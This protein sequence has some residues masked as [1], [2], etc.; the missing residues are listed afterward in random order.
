MMMAK[1]RLLLGLAALT[2]SVSAVVGCEDNPDGLYKKAPAGAGD[3]WNNGRTPA[4]FDPNAINGLSDSFNSSSRQELCSGAEKAER[5]KAMVRKPIIPPRKIAGIDL[6]GGDDWRGLDFRQAEQDLCQSK[7]RKVDDPEALG[8]AWGDSNEVEVDYSIANNSITNWQLNNGYRGTLDFKSRKHGLNENGFEDE[9]KANP[10]GEHTYSI[11]IGLQILKD[12]RPHEIDWNTECDGNSTPQSKCWQVQLTE[13][14]DGLMATFDPGL[15]STQANCVAEQKCLGAQDPSG[16]GLFGVRPLGVYF[17]VPNWRV[18]PTGSTPQYFYGF[19][20]KLMPF[21]AANLYVKLDDEG[22]FALSR[23]IGTGTAKKDC[24][25]H[26]G[27][28]YKDF[29]AN[30]V[31]VFEDKKDS[32]FFLTKLKGGMSHTKEAFNFSVEAV[33]LDFVTEVGD[34]KTVGDDWTPQNEDKAYEF[35]MDIRASGKVLNEFTPDEKAQTLAA[36]GAIYREYARRV[37]DD[38]HAKLADLYGTKDLVDFPAVISDPAKNDKGELFCERG[39]LFTPNDANGNPLLDSKGNPVQK[40]TFQPPPGCAPDLVKKGWAINDAWNTRYPENNKCVYV[41]FGIGAEQCLKDTPDEGCTGFEALITPGSHA[42]LAQSPPYDRPGSLYQ[43]GSD[44]RRVSIGFR[45]ASLGYKTALKA[46]DPLA[47]FCS[48]PA[49][50]DGLDQ[51]NGPQAP[52]VE[53]REDTDCYSK[54]C[55]SE[56]ADNVNAKKFCAPVFGPGRK[57]FKKCDD[58]GAGNKLLSSSF[59]RVL[60]VLAKGTEE[61]LPAALRDRKFYFRHFA[62]AL[63]KYLKAA[64]KSPEMEQPADL[65]SPEYMPGGH[66]CDA[67]GI[68]ETWGCEP[69][70]DHLLFTQ[71]IP[72]SSRDKWEYID[73]RFSKN[74]DGSENG[75][76]PMKVDYEILIDSSN[77]QN[78]RYHRKRTRPERKIYEAMKSD[79]LRISNLVGSPVL[80]AAFEDVSDTYDAHR[81]TSTLTSASGVELGKD[82]NGN[83]IEETCFSAPN[84]CVKPLKACADGGVTPPTAWKT[85]AYMLDDYGM[86]LLTNYRG[87]FKKKATAF[88]MG[89][90]SMKLVETL[91]YIKSARVSLPM[92]ADPY[93][94]GGGSTP[95]ATAPDAPIFIAD[96][97]PKTPANGIRIPINE[98]LDRFVPSATVVFGGSSL[99]LDIDYREEDDHSMTI[100]GVQSDSYM[101]N[102]FV[103]QDAG[104]G[105]IL[106]IEQYESADVILD[107]FNGHPDSRQDCGII[108]RFSAFG[109]FPLLISSRAAGLVANVGIGSGRGR[110]TNIEMFDTQLQ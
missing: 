79:N 67:N 66:A 54:K 71:M 35:E 63:V 23:Q 88:K 90:N 58:D 59:T 28:L 49:P 78:W 110:I 74:A 104:S 15:P 17:V 80:A 20:V 45:A 7:A 99:S 48:D 98:Q 6:A 38:I 10:F 40:C 55:V 19:Y 84:K 52:A 109:D 29:I 3:R 56:D 27:L 91:P 108:T 103:C 100:E 31:N 73:R 53:C 81:C 5:W 9:T 16:P 13:F 21:S 105:D 65:A 30:C 89:T 46:G 68:N 8:A 92:F 75:K 57:F 97:R 51:D 11:A 83:H 77:Q 47:R 60:N 50:N 64:P 62:S 26:L 33:K 4:I 24:K 34:D 87:A 44:P 101:G 32:D 22:P 18:Q 43:P 2:V 95:T 94:A 42:K 82:A 86:P 85:G 106:S 107:W 102:L 93:N 25:Q 36:T 76:E 1:H 61:N 39:S 70:P 12:G 14:Y 96:W 72:N 41:G 37:Q 69:E